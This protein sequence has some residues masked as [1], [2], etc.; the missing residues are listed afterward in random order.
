MSTLPLKGLRVVDA[1]TLAA[2]PLVAT[3]LGEFGAEVIKVEQPGAGDPLRTWGP[4][5]D[6]IGLVWKSVSRN[7]KCVTLDM[8][9]APGQELLHQLLDISDVFIV[10]TR[11]STLARWQLDY[12][13][14][15]ER[16]PELVMLHVTGYGHGG[17]ATDRP[18]FGTLAEAM[19]GFAHVTGQPDGPPT[20]PPFMLADG[21]A[22][23]AA[24]YAVMI[25]LYHRDMHRA[26]GQ[27]VD[28]SLVEPLA[29]LVEQ[30]TLAYDQLG[31]IQARTGNRVVASTPR[32]TYRTCD[33]T[34]DRGV[35]RRI[36]YRDGGV[37]GHRTTRSGKTS[38]VRRSGAEATTLRGD[39]RARRRLGWHAHIR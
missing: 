2:G 30:A 10:N 31:E 29:R 39:R 3:A 15:H 28:V 17:P 34:V 9:T 23:Q 18:G 22:A 5:R 12:H 27:L 21:V 11:P 36:E 33:D 13:S 1:A 25:A 35:Q 19:S 20:L 38:R 6:D 4:R 26:G 14:V 32:N 24:T 8:R 16:H 7:K 37:S